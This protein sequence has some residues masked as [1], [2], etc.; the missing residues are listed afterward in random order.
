MALKHGRL[1]PLAHFPDS[2]IRVPAPAYDQL[3]VL[4]GIEGADVGAVADQQRVRIVI[5]RFAR[6]PDIDDLVFA[7]GDDEAVRE[8]GGGGNDGQRVD[9]L[10]AVRLDGAVEDGWLRGLEV[11]YPHRVVSRCGHH[12]A[13]GGECDAADLEGVS[14]GLRTERLATHIVFVAAQGGG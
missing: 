8:C 12:G 14:S 10:L 13:G 3:A 4:A 1:A 7:A 6:L 11:P 2:R 5:K 9:K